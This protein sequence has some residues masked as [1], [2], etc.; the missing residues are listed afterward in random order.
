MFRILILAALAALPAAADP[1]PG[2]GDPPADVAVL[3]WGLAEIAVDLDLPLTGVADPQGYATWVG[4][5][6]LPAGVTDLG[7]RAE[8]NLEALSRLSPDLILGADQQADMARRLSTIA[9]TRI[10]DQ[11]SAAHDNAATAR[12]TYR[13]I[14]RL[15]GKAD[16]A[17][18][19]LARI[20][21]AMDAAGN[22]VRAAWGGAV[23]PVLPVRI[24]S[25]TSVRIHGPNSLATAALRGMGLTPAAGGPAT[26]WGFTLAPVAA[27]AEYP[28]AAIVHFDPFEAS[29]DLYGSPLWAAIPAVA[30]G[31]FATAEPAWTFGS[32]VS[33]E[34]LALRLA[35]ALVAMAPA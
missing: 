10:L 6:A 24:L 29:G 23:P 34:T 30:A 32:V 12:A 19:R 28:D 7:L 1:P 27:L 25:T 35:D 16:L 17:E 5:P 21:A 33:L 8:P 4:A 13:E 2:D 11:F 22:R 14:A 26:D 18:D 9:P 3:S 31:R 15:F 20:D